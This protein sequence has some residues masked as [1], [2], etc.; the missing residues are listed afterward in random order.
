MINKEF[1]CESCQH[2]FISL[3]PICTRCG[4]AATRVFL[5]APQIST[6]GVARRTDRILESSFKK[7][8]ISNFSNAGGVNK[9]SWVTTGSTASTVHGQPQ[10]MIQPTFARGDLSKYGINPAAMTMNGQPY[11]LP[12]PSQ[13][14]PMVL[15]EVGTRVGHFPTGLREQTSTFAKTD[16]RGNVVQINGSDGK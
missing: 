13:L 14:P 15:P 1:R 8:G 10:P 3:M 4:A 2:E 16:E 12:D 6:K 5:T 7:M 11:Q 9:V